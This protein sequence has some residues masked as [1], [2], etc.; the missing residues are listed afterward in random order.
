MSAT[1]TQVVANATGH[2]DTRIRKATSEVFKNIRY[3]NPVG[4][5]SQWKHPERAPV[6]YVGGNSRNNWHC[7]VGAPF[8]GEDATGT[9]AK[10]LA[11]IPVHA[12]SVVYL[13][14]NVDYIQ[15]LEHG[16][17]HRQAPTG[18]VRVSVE[19]FEGVLNGTS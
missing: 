3:M 16:H 13:T 9:E 17:S 6:G 4:E 12:G 18:M 19:L 11:A 7:T 14:N 1:M 8:V 2:I 15:R 5:P 10:I